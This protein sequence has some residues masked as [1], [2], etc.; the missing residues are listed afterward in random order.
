MKYKELLPMI[1]GKIQN[2][3]DSS[4]VSCFSHTCYSLGKS[5]IHTIASVSRTRYFLLLTQSMP[6][7]PNIYRKPVHLNIG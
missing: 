5:L 4:K 6:Y 1:S 2:T 7:Y 3:R